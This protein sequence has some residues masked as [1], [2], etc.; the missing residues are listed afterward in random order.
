M[1]DPCH[2]FRWWDRDP[3]RAVE[4][5]APNLLLTVFAVAAAL[6]VG[7]SV[8][9]RA[10]T[11]PTPIAVGWQAPLN[12]V[13]QPLTQAVTLGSAQMTGLPVVGS[14]FQPATLQPNLLPLQAVP[15]S[16]RSVQTS[17]LPPPQLR[18]RAADV[19]PT[20]LFF[21]GPQPV[22]LRSGQVTDAPPVA[23]RFLPATLANLLPLSQPVVTLRAAQ[24]TDLPPVRLVQ[25][26]QD[27]GRN[28]TLFTPVASAT[29]LALPAPAVSFSRTEG[30]STPFPLSHPVVPS[31]KSAWQFDL[32]VLPPRFTAADLRNALLP[33][34]E[35]FTAFPFRQQDWPLPIVLPLPV[36]TQATYIPSAAP[37]L[38]PVAVGG[39]KHRRYQIRI[40]K[41]VFEGP[42]EQIEEIARDLAREEIVRGSAETAMAGTPA[43]VEIIV[44]AK[45]RKPA[46]TA[47]TQ[48]A[49]DVRKAYIAA[50]NAHILRLQE[51]EDE[52][53]LLAL[54]T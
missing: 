23:A 33:P 29:S 2:S 51:E 50:V 28:P 22:T 25:S 27:V 8:L 37:P 53:A 10:S 36:L 46:L 19:A 43:V 14:P 24:A 32:P 6:P 7:K 21:L 1:R 15:P 16:L 11:P 34:L 35:S 54:L 12:T 41:Q 9:E 3:K 48:V 44:P 49:E 42:K 4:F 39:G 40:G 47:P 38:E 26:A 18:F 31:I 17:S 5:S 13:L 30:Y 52:E 20:S 45:K